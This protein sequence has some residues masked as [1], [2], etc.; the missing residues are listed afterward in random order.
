MLQQQQ[1][2]CT[3]NEA[4]NQQHCSVNSPLAI[5]EEEK[6][7]K[8]EKG[9]LSVVQPKPRKSTLGHDGQTSAV[10]VLE[11]EKSAVVQRT[12]S[13]RNNIIN[14]TSTIQQV[15][16]SEEGDE[17][18]K[19]EEK[20]EDQHRHQLQHQFHSHEEGE[21]CA[22]EHFTSNYSRIRSQ[23]SQFEGLLP[24]CCCCCSLVCLCVFAFALFS[25]VS[26]PFSPL[27]LLITAL[28][29][30]ISGAAGFFC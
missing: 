26:P 12:N 22:C 14:S 20:P 11:D 2:Q 1:E 19:E 24:L 4:V 13:A 28:L 15:L 25:T 3:N 27:V 21:V 17:E 5:V 7:K 8:E 16:T 23:F 29:L 6:K 18:D 9:I 10:A 30:F